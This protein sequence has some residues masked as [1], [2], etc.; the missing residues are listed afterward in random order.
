MIETVGEAGDT[1]VVFSQ[2]QQQQQQQQQLATLTISNSS[3]LGEVLGRLKEGD[4]AVDTAAD[5]EV[6]RSLGGPEGG[7]RGGIGRGGDGFG[8]EGSKDEG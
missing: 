5:S 6:P 1:A 2:K 8:G 3:H 4:P 7:G